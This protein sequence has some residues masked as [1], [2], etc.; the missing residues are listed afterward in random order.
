MPS[1]GDVSDRGRGPGAAPLVTAVRQLAEREVYG[2]V[3]AGPDLIVDSTFGPL[4]RFVEIGEPLTSSIY[5]IV[6]L[7]DD[8]AALRNRPGHAIELP[9]V[10]LVTSQG[11]RPR[12][13][14]SIAWSEEDGAF[15]LL[16]ARTESRSDFEAELTAQMRA[17]LI[18]ESELA[19]KTRELQ[20]ANA[21]LESYASIIS[22]DLQSPMRALRYAIDDLDNDAAVPP[23]AKAAL[24]KIRELSQR[25]TAM[26]SALLDY[27]GVT[28]LSDA[29][30]RVD[31][32]ALVR[33][34]AASID[35]PPG[36][37]LHIGGTWPVASTMAAPLDLVLRNL[38]D[39]AIKHHDRTVGIVNVSASPA[40]GTLTITVADDGPGIRPEHRDV[41]F[42]PFRKLAASPSSGQGMGLALVRRT[43]DSVGARITIESDAPANRGTTFTV[44]WPIG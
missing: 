18:A 24:G 30:E 8:I 13:T 27:A 29:V 38:I 22:H 42:L 3:W 26:L 16:L 23:G 12:A 39:N 2:L 20:R 5:A 19:T 1:T 40:A 35:R 9:D 14:L 37:H 33:T 15:L 6:G 10:T 25:M 41:V 34:V 43:A 21:D 28:R 7:E 11:R 31:T 17:R 36:L 32:A 4:A 44:H